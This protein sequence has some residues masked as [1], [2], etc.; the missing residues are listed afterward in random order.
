MDV[1][2]DHIWSFAPDAET[3]LLSLW[4]A[5]ADL[6]FNDCGG[7]DLAA[8]YLNVHN[9]TIS[10]R[11]TGE[12]ATSEQSF[13]A[14]H[15]YLQE[16][17]VTW[18]KVAGKGSYAEPDNA[19]HSEQLLGGSHTSYSRADFEAL[20]ATS[21]QIL[22]RQ[23]KYCTGTHRYAYLKRYDQNGLPPNVDLLKMVKDNWKQHENNTV[24]VDFDIFS[25]LDDALQEKMPWKSVNSD[26]H[27]VGFARDSGPDGFVYDQWNVWQTPLHNKHYGQRS[28]AF[29]VAITL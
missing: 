20:W 15:G 18:V 19:M 16:S 11:I 4:Q 12:C 14:S 2:G 3:G 24:N 28:V 27:N 8:K 29:Y 10:H 21:T 22:M 25:T 26:Y 7:L 9:T 1:E 23:C 17:A 6:V 13:L 5:R